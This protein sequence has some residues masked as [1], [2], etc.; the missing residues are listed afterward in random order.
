MDLY[1]IVSEVID[2]RSFSNLWYWVAL[3]VLW[4][5][6]SHWVLGVPYDMIQ[7][8]RR[9][10][11]Q[12]QLDV[13]TL[14]SINARRMLAITRTAAAPLFFGLAFFFT[15][16]TLLAFWYW[17]E[18]AQAVFFLTVW[19]L[20]VA[21]LSLRTALKIEGGEDLGAGLYQQLLLLRRM[22]QVVG[23][24]AILV[25]SMFG[26]WRNLSHSILY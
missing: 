4:S 18:F 15:V 23:M 22:V 24:F 10:G 21:W 2:L 25:T 17:V 3:A 16:L 8:A 11:G 5:S 26:M 12:A 14:A 9:Q 19:M 13:E 7:R 6:V 1:R 20:P